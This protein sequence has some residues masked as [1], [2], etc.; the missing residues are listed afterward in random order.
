MDQA[1]PWSVNMKVHYFVYNCYHMYKNDSNF[2]EVKNEPS[3]F[4]IHSK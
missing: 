4:Y 2:V 3:T 1:I